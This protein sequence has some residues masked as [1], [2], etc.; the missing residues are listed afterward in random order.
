MIK[1]IAAKYILKNYKIYIQKIKKHTKTK[2]LENKQTKKN[3]K[4]KTTNPKE[5]YKKLFK[6]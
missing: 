4:T 5:N 2:K 1:I 6:K 3:E